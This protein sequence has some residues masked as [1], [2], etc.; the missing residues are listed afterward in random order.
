[1]EHHAIS[2]DVACAADVVMGSAQKVSHQ[3]TE[4][5]E[6]AARSEHSRSR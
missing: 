2:A 1:M 4:A 5:R 3:W 6:A